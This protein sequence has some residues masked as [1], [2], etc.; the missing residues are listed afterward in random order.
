MSDRQAAEAL[1]IARAVAKRFRR[2]LPY[3][4]DMDD[5]VSAAAERIVKH[6]SRFDASQCTFRTWAYVNARGG[7]LDYLREVDTLSR[8]GRTAAS[9][10]DKARAS[11]ERTHARTP[12]PSELAEAVG[13]SVERLQEM[14]RDTS[15]L[16][17][18]IDVEWVASPK[19]F[20]A[21]LEDRERKRLVA[22][23]IGR[24]P[25]H[26]E[27][28]VLHRLSGETLAEIAARF[29]VTESYVCQVCTKSEATLREWLRETD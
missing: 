20:V 2:K 13:V 26:A 5:L 3:G 21:E 4:V 10:I 1:T 27:A 25:P 18:A 22:D 17:S 12:D 28:T 19:S 23:L 9:A 24:L 14:V 6:A 8:H 15:H 29:S 7:V 11:L 16:Q